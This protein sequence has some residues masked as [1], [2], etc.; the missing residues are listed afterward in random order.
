MAQTDLNISGGLQIGD[1]PTFTATF[2]DGTD[3]VAITLTDV[4]FTYKAPGTD[5]VTY[6]SA[7]DSEVSAG[8]TGQAKLKVANAVAGRH[9]VKAVWSSGTDGASVSGTF[10]VDPDFAI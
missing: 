1:V 8:T 9:F 10:K 7:S 4:T 3:P 2:T 6:N 5:A